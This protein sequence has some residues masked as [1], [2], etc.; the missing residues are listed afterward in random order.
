MYKFVLL[1]WHLKRRPARKLRFRA[2]DTLRRA[3]KILSNF[4]VEYGA[5]ANHGRLRFYVCDLRMFCI[6]L[7]VYNGSMNVIC[8]MPN[9]PARTYEF[10]FVICWV[11]VDRF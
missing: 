5:T 4:C 7:H 2:R 8:D 11:E 9:F 1:R 3:A 10:D 6:K